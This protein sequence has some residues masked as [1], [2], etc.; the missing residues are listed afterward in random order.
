MN[1]PI[2]CFLIDDDEDDQEIFA[3]ALKKLD[4][5][6]TCVFANDGSEALH[7]LQQDEAF[8]PQYIFLDLN[9]PGMTGKQCLPE[10]KKINR[11]Q[12]TPIIIFST[13]SE[14]KDVQE[15]RQLGADEFI[16]KPALIS[17]LTNQLA[18]L[19]PRHQLA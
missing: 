18:R 19:F 1:L 14:L 3:L 17:D 15:T 16:T 9:M 6:I 4:T 2:T 13:S 5:S 7:K 8:M 11:L 12:H 10:L